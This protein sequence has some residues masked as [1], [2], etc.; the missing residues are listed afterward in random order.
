[1]KGAYFTLAEPEARRVAFL[2]V[3]FK[4]RN[5]NPRSLEMEE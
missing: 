4:R 1:M 5:V 3:T 2:L